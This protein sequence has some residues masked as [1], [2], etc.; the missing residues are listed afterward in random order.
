M[1]KGYY[2]NGSDGL[3]HVLIGQNLSDCTLYMQFTIFQLDLN[4]ALIKNI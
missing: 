1:E 4:K 3:T 2:C